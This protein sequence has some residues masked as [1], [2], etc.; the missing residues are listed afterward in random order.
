MNVSYSTPITHAWARMKRMLFAP[1][2]FEAW[3]TL[4]F[5]L[6]LA[7][8][9]SF[10]GSASN[11]FTS[12]TK[13]ASPSFQL[14]EGTRERIL[15][16]LS[17]P[18]VLMGFAAV[19][20]VFLVIAVVLSYLSA[21]AEFV[22]FDDVAHERA[23][24]TQPWGRFGRL[25]NSLFLLRAA[26]SFLYIVPIA[27][28][29]VPLWSIG[30]AVLQ[31]EMFHL[32]MLTG[33]LAAGPF[34]LIALLLIG[35]VHIL[36]QDFVIPLMATRDLLATQAWRALLP[37]LRA[38]AGD[39]FA[40]ALLMLVLEVGVSLAVLVAGVLTC[41]IGLILVSI[42]YMNAVVLLPLHTAR[43][44]IGPEFLAQYGPEW[45]TLPAPQ[46]LGIEPAAYEPPPLA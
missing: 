16:W 32:S 3:L 30:A 40:Y 20:L 1:F 35:F 29:A 46:A 37:L 39:F 14:P 23:A 41:C 38:R 27:L 26:L 44:A 45:V 4:A 13:G 11:T 6:F 19:L 8:I 31:G 12:R 10:M 7:N 33:L 17:N 43:R 15:G 9:G 18:T 25:A 24:F 21:R 34:A 2:R 22:W 28:V 36:T 5:A 42:P